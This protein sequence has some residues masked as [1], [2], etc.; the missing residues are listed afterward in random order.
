MMAVAE[1]HKERTMTSHK[2]S[3]PTAI[4]LRLLENCGA[5]L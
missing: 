2:D 1:N 3:K 5:E 4:H